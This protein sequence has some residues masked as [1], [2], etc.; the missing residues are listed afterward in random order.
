[1]TEDAGNGAVDFDKENPDRKDWGDLYADDEYDYEEENVDFYETDGIDGDDD[2][3]NNLDNLFL[4]NDSEDGIAPGSGGG[5]WADAFMD[6][7]DSNGDNENGN[8]IITTVVKVP[9]QM[10]GGG[11]SIKTT[12]MILTRKRSEMDGLDSG[13]NNNNDQEDHFLDEN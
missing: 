5:D 13:N 8:V 10:K 2:D 1:M 3:T 4:D 7:K 12:V 9:M 6:A 11:A